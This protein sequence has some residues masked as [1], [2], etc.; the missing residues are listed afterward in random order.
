MPIIDIVVYYELQYYLEQC[1]DIAEDQ[2]S[3][4]IDSM[5]GPVA[6]Y[7][8]VFSWEKGSKQDGMGQ[9]TSQ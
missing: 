4:T 1:P 2:V 7:H 5:H 6:H 8:A 9:E 3:R